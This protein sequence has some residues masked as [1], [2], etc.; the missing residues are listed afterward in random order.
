MHNNCNA[1]FIY[2]YIQ[3]FK[4]ISEDADNSAKEPEYQHNIS[5]ESDKQVPKIGE[6]SEHECSKV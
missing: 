4:K 5:K 6:S 2:I 3:H 1:I